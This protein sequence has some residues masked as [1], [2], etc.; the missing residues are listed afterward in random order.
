MH[1][2]TEDA[3][4]TQNH[5]LSQKLDKLTKVL[6]ELPRGLRN[7]SQA[8][9][10]CDLCGGDHI[11]GQCAFTEEMQ[12]DVNYMGAQFQYKHGNFNQGNSSQGW[13]NHPS[14]GQSQNNT[15]GQVGNFR[16]Q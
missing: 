12:Q 15:S 10:L 3:A 1:L 2:P 16:Q 8:Q 6:F 7:I 4:A 11:N 9:Q 5:L 13:K 14:I